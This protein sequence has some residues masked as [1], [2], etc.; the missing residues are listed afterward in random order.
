MARSVGSTRV[1]TPTRASFVLGSRPPDLRAPRF[2][3]NPQ[4]NITKA[5]PRITPLPS[6][7]KTRNYAKNTASSGPGFGDTG[8]TNES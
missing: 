5:P 1:S 3:S 4:A 7:S 6:G 2:A 8:L